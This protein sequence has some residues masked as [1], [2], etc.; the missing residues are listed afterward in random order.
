MNPEYSAEA[1]EKRD[2]VIGR[3][4]VCLR[5]M[6][7]SHDMYLSKLESALSFCK[8]SGMTCETY[9][10]QGKYRKDASY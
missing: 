3:H 6:I 10:L 2:V 5:V 9:Y 1:S 8:I 4:K 7:Q